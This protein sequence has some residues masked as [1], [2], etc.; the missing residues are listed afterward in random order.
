MSFIY[1]FLYTV[2]CRSLRVFFLESM[3]GLNFVGILQFIV[4]SIKKI[5]NCCHIPI[6]NYL[7]ISSK[8]S[9]RKFL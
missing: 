6:M 5:N 4:L 9:L 7:I 1:I 3:F 8:R 2:C